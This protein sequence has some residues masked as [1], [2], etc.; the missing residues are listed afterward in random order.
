MVC[1]A[2]FVG[3]MLFVNELGSL[4]IRN[5]EYFKHPDGIKIVPILLMANLFLGCFYSISVW[6]RLTNNNKKGSQ[7]SLLAAIL[8][9]V[10]NMI[11][12]PFYGF[13]G[14]AWITLV[15]Y[16][17]LVVANYFWGQ[18]YYPVPY[19]LPKLG[20]IVLL[21]LIIYGLSS[22]FGPFIHMNKWIINILW[23]SLFGLGL[24]VIEK[25]F[26]TKNVRTNSNTHH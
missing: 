20:L 13:L 14:S 16:L 10:L 21:S 9:V 26:V 2:I 1:S 22:Y 5:G 17:F 18:K 7:L 15:V 8:T 4:L 6:Y 23:L 11:L 12:I 24:Y 19:N 25:N 3:T